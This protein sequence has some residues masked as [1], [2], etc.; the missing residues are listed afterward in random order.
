MAKN[1]FVCDCK[2]I[3]EELVKVAKEKMYSEDKYIKAAEFF[4]IVGDSTR[5]KIVSALL[6]HEMCVGDLANVLSM[7]KSSISHQL[8]KMK[9]AGVVKSRRNGKEIY[10]SLDDEHVAEIF[11]LT[12]EHIGHIH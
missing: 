5:C 6:I 3:N 7:T 2:P 10:Y 4:K 8:S 1:E 9:D 12:V 11:E